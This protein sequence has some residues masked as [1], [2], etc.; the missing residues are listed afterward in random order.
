MIA[1]QDISFNVEKEAYRPFLQGVQSKLFILLGR[2][3]IE[4]Q[5]T[6]GVALLAL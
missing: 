4:W 2:H 5:I 1:L 3:S 6:D